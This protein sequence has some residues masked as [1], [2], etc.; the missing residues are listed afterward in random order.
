MADPM[1]FQFDLPAALRPQPPGLPE[2]IHPRAWAAAAQCTSSRNGPPHEAIRVV[3][4]HAT[5]G[6]ST[7]GAVS[8]MEEGRASF[9]WIV[10]DENETAH[11][12]FVWACAPER[13]AAWHVRR[14]CAHPD[15]CNGATNLNRVSLGIEIVNRQSGGDRFS[16]WQIEATA[17][18]VRYAWA[19]YPQLRHVVSHARLDP[20]RRT[21]PGAN[22]PWAEFSNR[23]LAD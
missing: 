14:A 20:K 6:A 22:F 21:D 15:V 19:K 17:E 2:K 18:I 16:D 8:V 23:V 12:K 3:V 9:H 10:P 4:I 5:A 1:T 7:E 11:G 13:T